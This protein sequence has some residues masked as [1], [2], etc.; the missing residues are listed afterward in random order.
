MIVVVK[1]IGGGVCSGCIDK[2]EN[3]DSKYGYEIGCGAFKVMVSY[4]VNQAPS[5]NSH[6]RFGF[7]GILRFFSRVGHRH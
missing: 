6:P 1:I 3:D 4:A 2:D 5:E 7:G